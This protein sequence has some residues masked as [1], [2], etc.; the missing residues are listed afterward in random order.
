MADPID[1]TLPDGLEYGIVETDDELEE[2]IAFNSAIHEPEDGETLRRLIE[3]MPG[4]G[5][6][7]NYY[8]RDTD[9]GKIVSSLNAIPS[10]WAYNGIPINNLELGFVG[11][12]EEYRKRGLIRKLYYKYFE[13]QFHRGRYHISNIQ[14]IPYFYRQFGY[15]FLIPDWRQVFLRPNQIPV[16]PPDKKPDWMR[17]S[18][19]PATKSNLND[20]I[21]LYDKLSTGLL[22]STIRDRTLWELQEKIRKDF[23]KD[24]STY[25]VKRGTEVLGYFRLVLRENKKEP[26]NSYLNVMESSISG[27]DGVRRTLEF[28]RSHC[29]ELGFHRIAFSG[30]T[31]S[32]LSRIGL[33]LGGQMSRG[34]KHQLRIRDMVHFLKRIRPALQKRLRN[35]MFAG[36]TQEVTI[37]TYR[38]RYVLDFQSGKIKDIKDLGVHEDGKYLDFRT[39]PNDFVRLLLGQYSP[40][41]LSHQDMDFIIQGPAKSL[42]ATLFPKQESFIGYYYC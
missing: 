41:E 25:V 18:I 36:L 24:F 39:P 21:T 31:T 42:I 33:D 15:D 28:L 35:T 40:E 20:I 32:N 16:L 1:L 2:L 7:L 14:G 12:L 17:L 23:A 11:T 22:V 37:N 9:S 10:V 29:I 8:I 4:F 26:E 5:R 19:R 6:E 30:A 34:W 3:K 38:H 27:I 13:K